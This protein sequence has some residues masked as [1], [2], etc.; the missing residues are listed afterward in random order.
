MGVLLVILI[1]LWAVRLGVYLFIRVHRM[2]RDARFDEMHNHFFRYAG[3]WLLQGVAVFLISIPA[4]MLIQNGAQTVHW[5]SIAGVVFFLF[6][7]AI[8]ALADLQKFRFK[9]NPANAHR[10]T[11]VGLW[12]RMRHPN[13]LGE[14][15]VWVGIYLFAAPGLS[16]V[17]AVIGLV[18]PLFIVV[19]LRYVSGIP[20]LEKAALKKWGNDPA[21]LNYRKQT[22]MLFPKWG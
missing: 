3:F 21:Y 12:K 6:G 13:Y 7:W 11:D 9:Q 14:M 20:L 2:G 15:M 18:S 22:G 19:L 1:S 4:I 5:I 17:Q 10:W 16:A 8:E